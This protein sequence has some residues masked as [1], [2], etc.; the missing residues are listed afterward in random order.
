MLCSAPTTNL[1]G[2]SSDTTNVMFSKHHSVVSIL[3][4]EHRNVVIVKCSCHLLH[5][6]ASKSCLKLSRTVEDL[7]WE[8][9][10]LLLAEATLTT[11]VSRISRVLFGSNSQNFKS[12][13]NYMET[14]ICETIC[15]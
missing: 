6:V 1:V 8:I 13:N 9:W 11:K 10:V 15:W 7:F 5:L 14:T 2:F 12:F 4:S 3:K